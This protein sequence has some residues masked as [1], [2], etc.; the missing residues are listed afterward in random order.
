MFRPG[1]EWMI[2]EAQQYVDEK[3]EKLLAR[4]K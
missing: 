1:N 4:C 3:W 2:E